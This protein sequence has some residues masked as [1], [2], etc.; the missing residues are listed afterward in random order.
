MISSPPPFPPPK[1][2]KK[3]QKKSRNKA[4]K[5]KKKKEKG[6]KKKPPNQ[7]PTQPTNSLFF[8]WR[9]QTPG[10]RRRTGTPQRGDLCI[11]MVEPELPP[12]PLLPFLLAFIFPSPFPFLPPGLPGLCRLPKGLETCPKNRVEGDGEGAMLHPRLGGGREFDYL[13]FF[14]YFW[15]GVVQILEPVLLFWWGV[16]P[17]A[18]RNLGYVG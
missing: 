8:S 10:Q 18:R 15:E 13:N 17:P 16:P 6:G 1:G 11:K 14:F 7:Q 12:F 3:K 5:R 4:A 2:E 9:A